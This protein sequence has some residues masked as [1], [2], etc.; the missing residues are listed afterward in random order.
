MQGLK[1]LVIG[2][3][4]AIVVMI[5]VIITTIVNRAAQAPES[6]PGFDMTKVDI[7]HGARIAG[8]AV[9]EGRVIVQ[10]EFSDRA[11]RL[12]IIDLGS[13]RVL[14]VINLEVMQ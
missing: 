14:G 9:G 4:V 10:L 12:L 3:G 8:T 5:T 13:G 7:P 2:M 1:L 11:P 6:L